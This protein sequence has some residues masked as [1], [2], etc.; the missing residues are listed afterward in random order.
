MTATSMA[1]RID[2][3]TLRRIV[4]FVML[5]YIVAYL[6]RVNISYASLEMNADI[7]LSTAA[8]GFGASIFFVGYIIFEVPSNVL[9]RR[10]GAR[11][12]LAR[13]I[14]SWGI[15]ATC[16]ALVQGPTSFYVL[17][18]LL[19]VA[20]A[21][22]FPGIILYLTYWF[23]AKRRGKVTAMFM[24]AIPLSGLIG[25]PL[26]TGLMTVADGLFGLAGWQAMYIIEGLPAVAL[27][28]VTWFYLVDRPSKARWLTNEESTWLENRLAAEAQEASE[29]G[30]GK[31]LR[32][33]THPLILA[34]GLIYIGLQFGEYAL[35][36]FLPQMV[37]SFEASFGVSLSLIQIGLITAIPSFFGVLAM[38]LWGRQSDRRNERTWHLI[39]PAVAGA[40]G[41][42]VSSY[43]G[44]PMLM[45]LALSLAA[46]GVYSSLPIFWQLP[47]LYLKGTALAV[48]IAMANSMGNISGIIGP[49]II[50][51]LHDLT[52]SFAT[53]TWVIAAFLITSAGGA[54]VLR[55]VGRHKR[56]MEEYDK[57]EGQ[58]SPTITSG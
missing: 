53:G 48:G 23:P 37:Q 25:A 52:G 44:T 5:L 49:S 27:G 38:I 41:I 42:L 35:G 55:W 32:S 24:A 45:I 1:S 36:F 12:W 30:Q 34:L 14:F 13:I 8:Y 51:G 7:G 3:K 31:I 33:L 18:F 19:G 28:V 57:K 16:M 58:A 15:L 56:K 4:P 40:I 9:L 10:F 21:G 6:D 50:G 46:A 2:R 26:S 47:P 39:I 20:E 11:R 29:V 43:V 54:I 17:R 22:F